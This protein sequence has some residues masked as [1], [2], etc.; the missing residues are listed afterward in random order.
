MRQRSAESP[1]YGFAFF[2]TVIL[3]FVM[4]SIPDLDP[5]PALACV[6]PVALLLF[7]RRRLQ[8]VLLSPV[9][10]AVVVMAGTGLFGY[11]LAPHLAGLEGGGIELTMPSEMRTATAYVFAATAGLI[12]IGGLCGLGLTRHRRTPVR[13]SKLSSM[14]AVVLI[15]IAMFPMLAVVVSLGSSLYTRE[16]YLAG[17]GGSNLFGLGQQLAIAAVAFLGY[18]VAMRGGVMRVLG[19]VAASGY[20]LL[21]IGLGSR[22]MALIPVCFAIGYA[23]AGRRHVWFAIVGSVIL[24]AAILPIPL[25]LRGGQ[26]HGLL[27]Y[28]D[29][30]S[31]FSYASVDW[32]VTLNNLLIA[33]P[34]AGFTAFGVAPIPIENLWIGLNPL[35]GELVGWY[36]IS[37][38][39]NLNRWTP[40]SMVGEVANYGFIALVITWFAVGL[41][42]AALEVRAAKY[43]EKGYPLFAIAVVGL[44]ALFTIQALQYTIRSSTRM[45]VYA[46]IVVLVAELFI[47][48]RGSRK[49]GSLSEPRIP[50]VA[51]LSPR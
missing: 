8:M 48:V 37:D 10:I 7:F 32:D 17:E 50:E 20:L 4:V 44:T 49:D 19:I 14:T 28:L 2:A 27:P 30:L 33:F 1:G 34:I 29:A 24:T 23:L 45:L 41:V 47:H 51:G 6:L 39:M 22:R 43:A 18:I 21:F 9:T 12:A 36:D 15:G 31:G 42:L 5:L 16:T 3:V 35:P 13:R 25:Y 46:V 38:S 40:Y 11:A 26:I